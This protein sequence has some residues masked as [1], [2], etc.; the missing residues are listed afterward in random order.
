MK[1]ELGDQQPPDPYFECPKRWPWKDTPNVPHHVAAQQDAAWVKDSG[2]L[3]LG[4]DDAAALAAQWSRD[5][6]APPL[7]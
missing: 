4:D 2:L 5:P 6:R 1:T 7:D 3:A